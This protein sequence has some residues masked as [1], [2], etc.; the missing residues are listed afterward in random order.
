MLVLGLLAGCKQ[1]LDLTDDPVLETGGGGAGGDGTG[2]SGGGGGGTSCDLVTCQA[3]HA[4]NPCVT[5]SCSAM[6]QC[7][8]TP[9]EAGQ[10][11]SDPEPGD[12]RGLACDGAGATTL[13]NDAADHTNNGE[14]DGNE[15]DV[16]CGGGCE[17]CTDGRGCAAAAD[18][19]SRV[20]TGDVCQVPLCTDGVK[21]GNE[22]GADCGGS[23]VITALRTCADGEGCA[24]APDCQSGVCVEGVC[25]ATS[26]ADD[27]KNGSETGIDCGGPTCESCPLLLLLSGSSSGTTLLAGEY[28][29]EEP[30]PTWKTAMITGTTLDA[31]ALAVTATRVGVGVIRDIN[32]ALQFVTWKRGRWSAAFQ[33]VPGSRLLL[34]RPT[35]ASDSA[36]A[37]VAYHASAPGTLDDYHYFNARFLNG[38]WVFGAESLNLYGPSAPQL[39]ARGDQAALAFYWNTGVG[40]EVNHL[41]VMERTTTWQPAVDLIEVLAPPPTLPDTYSSLTNYNIPPAITVMPQDASPG[42]TDA[43][44]MVAFVRRTTAVPAASAIETMRR[45]RMG[46]WSTMTPPAGATTGSEVALL[47]LPSGEALLAYRGLDVNR[48]LFTSHYKPAEGWSTPAQV[49]NMDIPVSISSSPALVRGAGGRLA[50]MAYV[51]TGGRVFHVRYDGVSWSAPVEV[52]TGATVA[53]A[54][55]P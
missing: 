17:P 51:D 48:S 30:S 31:P 3:M 44:L 39:A 14:R 10:P 16:D 2:V 34:S 22:T 54:S 5:A 52:G 40:D 19:E 28:R 6:G 47:G 38:T 55:V 23:C 15:T 26:C 41:A 4:G 53:L 24:V 50:E 8:A 11:V 12:C 21:N 35:I 9:V 46:A 33:T 49:M 27:V 36:T 29:P 1:L 37:M 25:Q 42:P 43:D 7:E 20:C 32:R 13:V 45:D 18:C